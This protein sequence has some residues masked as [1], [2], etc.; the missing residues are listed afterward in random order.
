MLVRMCAHTNIT[1]S[2]DAL[3]SI[4]VKSLKHRPVSVQYTQPG[5]ARLNAVYVF[6]VYRL[7]GRVVTLIIK[8]KLADILVS[9]FSVVV[10]RSVRNNCRCARQMAG[11]ESDE[12]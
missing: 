12:C 9:S 4:N 11:A 3:Q 6:A 7:Y 10:E 5:T 1:V 8:K 2:L